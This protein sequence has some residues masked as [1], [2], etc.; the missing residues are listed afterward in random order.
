MIDRMRL[1][2]IFSE[3]VGF[4]VVGRSPGQGH[5][6][7]TARERRWPPHSANVSEQAS[8]HIG[9][10]R[11]SFMCPMTRLGNGRWVDALERGE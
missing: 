4:K 9:S 3:E 1:G 8:K 5:R 7:L 11:S 6:R 2:R 10:K